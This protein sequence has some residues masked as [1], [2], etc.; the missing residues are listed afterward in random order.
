VLHPALPAADLA[1]PTVLVHDLPVVVGALG[2][3]AIFSAEL[4]AADAVL[5]MLATSFSQ[6]LYRR[7]LRPAAP[8]S[9]LLRIAR[10]AAIAGSVCG[11]GLAILFPTVIAA[12][13]VFYG[14]LTVLFFVPVV[15]AL[16]SGRV[17]PPEALAG[18]GTG[19]AVLAAVH[20][21]TAGAGL[22][23]WRPDT[24][25]LAASGLAFAAM[26]AARRP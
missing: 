13:T 14:L 12:L 26:W 5:F 1:L 24:M 22:W 8:E 25:A 3:A 4:S 21:G 23:G 15:A 7:F 18:M 10:T 2:L 19:V 11:I 20:V 9:S 17:G 16:L 6:D